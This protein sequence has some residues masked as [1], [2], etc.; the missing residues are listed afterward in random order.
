MQW[1][2]KENFLQGLNLFGNEGSVAFSFGNAALDGDAGLRFYKL[3]KLGK[4]ARK[5]C[6]LNHAR[7]IGKLHKDHA[8]IILR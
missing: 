1:F 6:H 3:T 4:Y 2:H 7:E 5:D 8:F